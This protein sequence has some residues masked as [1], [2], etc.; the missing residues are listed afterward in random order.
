MVNW[1]DQVEGHLPEDRPVTPTQV[2]QVM[3]GEGKLLEL[4]LI[5]CP[6]SFVQNLVSIY[7]LYL[8]C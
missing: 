8:Y 3:L 7:F 6:P 4:E 1:V 5:G 2:V